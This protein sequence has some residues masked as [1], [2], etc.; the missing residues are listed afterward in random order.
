M[1]GEILTSELRNGDVITV[2]D[3]PDHD[4]LILGEVTLSG[5]GGVSFLN[6]CQSTNE[7]ECDHGYVSVWVRPATESTAYVSLTRWGQ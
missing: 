2:S 3:T 4:W 7:L 5:D 6:L 1:S